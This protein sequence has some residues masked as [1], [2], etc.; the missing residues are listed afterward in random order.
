MRTSS[1][2]SRLASCAGLAALGLSI[3]IT[4]VGWH[5]GIDRV[6]GTA[7]AYAFDG[8]TTPST[9]ALA[10]GEGLRATAHPPESIPGKTNALT[11]LQYA[12]DQGQPVAQ[13]KL[14]RMYA[15]GD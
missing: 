11:A 12:A 2:I 9:A 6:L 13:W 1:T 14:G 4:S 5:R 7:P 8:T 3:V 15:D 10:P